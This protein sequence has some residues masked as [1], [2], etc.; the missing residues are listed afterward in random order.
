MSANQTPAPSEHAG[1]NTSSLASTNPSKRRRVLLIV[2]SIFGVIAIVW[3]LLWRL[4]F[5]T[6]VSTDNAY[7]GGNQVSLSSQVPGIVVAILADNTEYVKAGQPLVRLDRTDADIRLSKARS[8][9]VMAIRQVRGQIDSAASADAVVDARK[10]QLKQARAN[11]SRRLPLLTEHAETPEIIQHLRDAVAQAKAALHTAQSQAHAAHA[12]I[13]NTHITHNPTVEQARDNFRAAWVAA[14]RNTIF[15]P[16]SG[17]VAE[18]SVQVGNSITPGQQ[19]MVIVPLHHL[20]VDANFKETQL[21]HVRAGEPVDITADLYGDQVHYHGTIVGL[22][23][24][25]G[26]VFSLLPAQNA[27]G[28]W[29]KVIQRVPVR[30]SLVDAELD[31]HPLRL[32]LSVHAVVDIRN[33]NNQPCAS[34]KAS[35]A[36]VTHIYDR[37]GAQADAA[38]ASIIRANLSSTSH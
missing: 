13:V 38:A 20:W 7:V 3:W 2:A 24:G 34:S 22:G 31:R 35:P 30:I 37:I 12:A 1:D 10:V 16:V 27:T 32:G 25:T 5:S 6:H 36:A 29:I 14:K 18:R 15:A 19:L 4:V 23:A 21:R 9:L 8:A 28:N 17:Y 33:A 26:S 11:L